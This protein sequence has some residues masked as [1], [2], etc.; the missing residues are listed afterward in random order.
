MSVKAAE[1]VRVDDAAAEK[2]AAELLDCELRGLSDCDKVTD[3]EPVNDDAADREM[4]TVDT[5]LSE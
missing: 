1:S 5:R 2:V 3:A 4:E